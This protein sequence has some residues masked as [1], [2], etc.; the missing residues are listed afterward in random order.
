MDNV[1]FDI[2]WIQVHCL[3]IL[4]VQYL[5]KLFVNLVCSVAELFG[6]PYDNSSLE[7]EITE[8]CLQCHKSKSS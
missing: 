3:G 8:K 7:L 6:I 4:N 5:G 1:W 2:I